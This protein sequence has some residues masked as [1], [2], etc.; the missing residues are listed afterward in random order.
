MGLINKHILYE[1]LDF[2]ALGMKPVKLAMKTGDFDVIAEA[3][4]KHFKTRTKPFYFYD[5]LD[6][7]K[8]L[9]IV[10]KDSEYSDGI[11]KEADRIL[12]DSPVMFGFTVDFESPLIWDFTAYG[13]NG[14]YGSLINRFEWMIPIGQAYW[15]TGDE[16]YAVFFTRVIKQ[17]ILENPLRLKQLLVRGQGEGGLPWNN[18]LDIGVRLKSLVQLFA[19]FRCYD[20]W[21]TDEYIDFLNST[22]NNKNDIAWNY[23][24]RIIDTFDI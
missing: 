8:Q 19:Y 22:L 7:S 12:G 11:I 10:L 18:S 3:V 2:N 6:K 24:N 5:A 23:Y 21:R 4:V 20:G 17:W 13:T 9:D 16:K 1:A 15:I 14:V